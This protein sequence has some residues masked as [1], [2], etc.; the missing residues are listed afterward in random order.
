[1]QVISAVE[2]LPANKAKILKPAR[3]GSPSGIA[4]ALLTGCQDR[5]Y[6][7]GLAMALAKAG[8]SVDVIGSDEIDSPELHTTANLRFLNF[9]PGH[10]SDSN[11]ARKLGK[12]LSYYAKLVGYATRPGPKILH[13]LWNYKLEYFDRTILMLYYRALGKKVVLTAHN[14]NQA[15]RDAKD[16]WVNRATLQ[17]QYRL[18]NHIF[19]HTEK[20]KSELCQNF[21]VADGRITVLQYPVNNA[22]PDTELSP[23]EAK[24]R[25]GLR[26]DEKAILF[27]GRIVPYK[28]IEYLLD[29]FRLLRRQRPAN[30]RLI[31]V[32]E[33][34]KGS[35]E[36]LREI[37]SLVENNCEHAEIILRT[38]FIP[39]ED[40]EIYLKGADVMALPYKEI[41][42]SGI[43]MMAYSFGL[44]VVATDVGSFREDVVE[45]RTG[46]LCEPGNSAALAEAIERYFGSDLYRNLKSRRLE[47]KDYANAKH[48]WHMVAGLTLD[49]YARSLT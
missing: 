26:E 22:F 36:C 49:A 3:P 44:P 7:F 2:E 25:L 16:S 9:R 24:K 35:D 8:A 1:M 32:G 34:K 47:L 39:D 30:Y 12:L 23:A 18:C 14:V 17:V 4:M 28:G 43:L 10:S 31:L 37:K 5:H 38:E 48:S 29:A 42:Q 20:M 11:F 19:V 15:R 27:F 21:G 40:I 45:G 13:I 41:F 6:A 46:F 33:P